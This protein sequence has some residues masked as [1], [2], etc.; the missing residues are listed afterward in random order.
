MLIADL[1]L[2]LSRDASLVQSLHRQSSSSSCSSIKAGHH[3]D[4]PIISHFFIMLALTPKLCNREPTPEPSSL[5]LTIPPIAKMQATLYKDS[6]SPNIRHKMMYIKIRQIAS[7]VLRRLQ[8]SRHPINSTQHPLRIL[9]SRQPKYHH[10]LFLFK[11]SA[12]KDLDHFEPHA[13]ET[14]TNDFPSFLRDKRGAVKL[15]KPLSPMETWSETQTKCTNCPNEEVR[16]TALQLRSA[17][18]ARTGGMRITRQRQE[19]GGCH[20]KGLLSRSTCGN[21]SST[22]ITHP[23]I[24]INAVLLRGISH[25]CQPS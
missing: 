21:P 2:K 8:R 11:T 16:Y 1:N 3:Q 6:V 7:S 17:V 9:R 22:T 14:S 18:S 25:I 19:K 23:A 10:T 12:N 15:P 4:Q 24:V 13:A 20:R 5:F